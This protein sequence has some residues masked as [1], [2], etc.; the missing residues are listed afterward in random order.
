MLP[1]NTDPQRMAEVHQIVV[2]SAFHIKRAFDFKSKIVTSEVILAKNRD[3]KIS[4]TKNCK[5]F[6]A[7]Q[8]INKINST[9][10]K[11]KVG[12]IN[13]V[14]DTELIKNCTESGTASERRPIASP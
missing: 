1:R 5:A 14:K 3:L 6:K 2:A 8:K 7:A 9:L 12:R 10:P 11:T 4:V 13:A